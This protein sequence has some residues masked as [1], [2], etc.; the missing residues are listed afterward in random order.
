MKASL[1]FLVFA[2]GM[3]LA[4]A[5]T[6]KK[7]KAP[8]ANNSTSIA[9]VIKGRQFIDYQIQFEKGQTI[10]IL[11]TGSNQSNYFNILPPGSKDVAIYN[12]SI[13]GN[14]YKGLIDQ[15]GLYTIRVYLMRSAARRNENSKFVLKIKL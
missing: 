7:I 14:K 5:Q 13:N 9:G 3:N 4:N 15:S 1:L 6:I 10:E 12:S 11:L 2:F 8:K